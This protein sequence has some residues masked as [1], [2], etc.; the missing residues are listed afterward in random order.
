MYNATMAYVLLKGR[1]DRAGDSVPTP[2]E[3]YWA[4][5]VEAAGN[6]LTDKGINLQDTTDD[7]M[8]VADLAAERLLSRDKAGGLPL[9]LTVRIRQRWLKEGRL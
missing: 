6:E 5:Q 8:L 4:A 2:L 1:M 9:W 3:S 7:N